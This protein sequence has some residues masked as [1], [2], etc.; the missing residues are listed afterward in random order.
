MA[1]PTSIGPRHPHRLVARYAYRYYSFGD[2]Q[3]GGTAFYVKQAT[4]RLLEGSSRR[5]SAGIMR[6]AMSQAEFDIAQICPNGHVANANFQ[7]YPEHNQAHCDKCGEATMVL[8]PQCERPIRGFCHIPRVV[9]FRYDRPAHCHE[10][11]AAFPWTE[12]AIQAAIELTVEAGNL[13]DDDAKVIR[14][15]VNDIVRETP[16]THLGAARFKRILSKVGEGTKNAVRDILVD[17][18]SES[19]KKAIW[20]D[21]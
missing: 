10:C 18:V 5:A 16:R 8:C 13:S 3:I 4:M 17:V 6:V 19:V 20:P 14:E 1:G 7:R 2:T 12:R 11:G 9:S 15:S 21:K